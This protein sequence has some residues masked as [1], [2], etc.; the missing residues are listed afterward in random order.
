MNK[1]YINQILSEGINQIITFFMVMVIIVLLSLLLNP[2]DEEHK[3]T[4]TKHKVKLTNLGKTLVG[5]N[6]DGQ[7]FSP[8]KRDISGLIDDVVRKFYDYLD[9]FKYKDYHLFSI[10][11][12]KINGIWRNVSF[13]VM[14]LIFLTH[15]IE[16]PTVYWLD[17]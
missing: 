12:L 6:K 15:P 1:D 14:N 4:I 17:I 10:G 2:T 9:E 13:G 5:D 16:Q 11:R 3:T 8:L 7:K